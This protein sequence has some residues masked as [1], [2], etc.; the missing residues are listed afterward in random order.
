VFQC[1]IYLGIH[2]STLG[3]SWK[4]PDSKAVNTERDRGSMSW[5]ER[6]GV[7]SMCAGGDF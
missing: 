7:N 1:G 6:S 5:K 2:K 4:Q 3:L